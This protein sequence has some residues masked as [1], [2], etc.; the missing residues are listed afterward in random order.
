MVPLRQPIT[1]PAC[2]NRVSPFFFVNL[3]THLFFF[4][5][6]VYFVFF[7][8]FRFLLSTAR[9]RP[10]RLRAAGGDLGGD[11]AGY[12]REAFGSRR[13]GEGGRVL[14]AFAL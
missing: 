7:F 12:E 13:T 3:F 9:H 2:F 1:R 11:G 10:G 4:G 14:S 5:D 6:F 8:G